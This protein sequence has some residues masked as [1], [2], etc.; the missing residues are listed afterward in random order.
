MSVNISILVSSHML[1]IEG[2]R[3]HQKEG[4]I[5]RPGQVGQCERREVV[6]LSVGGIPIRQNKMSCLMNS[7]NFF[8]NKPL[9]IQP[10][11]CSKIG[12]QMK[13]QCVNTFCLNHLGLS[14]PLSSLFC[15]HGHR[16]REQKMRLYVYFS[17]LIRLQQ[18][19]PHE[20]GWGR[21]Q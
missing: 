9:H 3:S 18:G 11:T 16:N 20:G 6:S 12:E 10:L 17:R 2:L 8:P 21:L 19:T 1:S 7:F 15:G 13:T 4:D 14:R 5:R